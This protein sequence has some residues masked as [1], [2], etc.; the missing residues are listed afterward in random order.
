MNP[1]TIKEV[2]QEKMGKTLTEVTVYG[3]FD[4]GG[5]KNPATWRFAYPLYSQKY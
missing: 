5:D 1:Q 2:L 3:Y 4:D